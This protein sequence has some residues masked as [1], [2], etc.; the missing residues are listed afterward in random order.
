MSCF[1]FIIHQTNLLDLILSDLNWRTWGHK[2]PKAWLQGEWMKTPHKL[3]LSFYIFILAINSIKIWKLKKLN[4]WCVKVGSLNAASEWC[5]C[6]IQKTVG[7]FCQGWCG[8]TSG[9][10]HFIIRAQ[11]Q[12]GCDSCLSNALQGKLN[13][14]TKSYWVATNIFCKGHPVLWRYACCQVAL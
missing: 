6:D 3:G 13:S 5:Y 8:Q 12:Q 4:I 2:R 9:F 1:L 10:H 7:C 11:C 14:Y